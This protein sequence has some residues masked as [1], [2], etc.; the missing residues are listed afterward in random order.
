[1]GTKG[2]KGPGPESPQFKAADKTCHKHLA[3]V[4]AMREE[5]GR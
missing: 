5:A 4:E 1:M 2:E 3:E